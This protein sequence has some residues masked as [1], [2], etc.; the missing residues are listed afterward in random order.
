M[1]AGIRPAGSFSYAAL[2][3]KEIKPSCLNDI[4]KCPDRELCKKCVH[5]ECK[6]HNNDPEESRRL[7][8]FQASGS[9]AP[10]PVPCYER[11]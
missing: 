1:G 9:D 10:A 8:R 3:Y 4:A 11:D 2:R 6:E 7:Q 5:T